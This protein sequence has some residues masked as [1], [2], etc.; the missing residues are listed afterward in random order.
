MEEGFGGVASNPVNSKKVLMISDMGKWSEIPNELLEMVVDRLP[1]I[2]HIR[3]GAVCSSWYQVTKENHHRLDF[4]DQL[5]LMIIPDKERNET[6]GFYSITKNKVYNIQLPEFHG[7]WCCVSSKGWVVTIDESGNVHLLNPFTST[8]IQLPSL[9]R[10]P[11]N[12]HSTNPEVPR[13]YRYIVKTVLSANPISTQDYIVA[14][15]VTYDWKLSFYK[16]GDEK[17]TTI[18]NEWI[19]Y[20]DVIYY[21]D[22][23]YAITNHNAVVTCDFASIDNPKFTVITPPFEGGIDRRYLVESSGKLLKVER[24]CEWNPDYEL[25]RDGNVVQPCPEWVCRTDWFDVFELDEVTREWIL[26]ESLGDE[27]LFVGYSNSFSLSASDFPQGKGNCIYFTD[28]SE[29]L[30]EWG[31]D[32]GV[33]NLEDKSVKPFY[34]SSSTWITK[35][36]WV[37]PYFS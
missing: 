37:P 27:M 4:Q 36:I 19:H 3:F 12:Q 20:E 30:P 23:F 35:P 5:P 18:N 2:D 22:K 25:D 17:W 13:N 1:L 7:K 9:N 10:F 14:T 33:F 32:N 34:P 16:P 6:R 11:D 8:Q 31:L 28:N 26:I 24:F 29:N 15:I 21:K